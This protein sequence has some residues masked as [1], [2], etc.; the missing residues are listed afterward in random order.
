[1]HCMK[2]LKGMMI[3]KSLLQIYIKSNAKLYFKTYVIV[4]SQRKFYNLKYFNYKEDKNKFIQEALIRKI[5]NKLKESKRKKWIKAKNHV[6]KQKYSIA[7]K[8]YNLIIWE[9]IWEYI[10]KPCAIII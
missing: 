9:N 7:E 5:W 1:M 6:R 8:I 2:Q 4:Q 10:K 3:S